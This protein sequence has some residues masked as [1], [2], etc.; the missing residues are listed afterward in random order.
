DTSIW[1]INGSRDLS[2]QQ[3]AVLQELVYY[4]DKKAQGYDMPAFKVIAEKILL[5]IAEQNPRTLAALRNINNVS[6]KLIH[7]HGRGLIDA[8]Q[9]GAK[10][11]KITQP[12]RQKYKNGYPERLE[13]LR[14]WRKNKAITMGV[15][16]DVIL[17]RDLMLQIATE[18]PSDAEHLTKILSP[19]PWRLEKYAS[20]IQSVLEKSRL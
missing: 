2:P 19:T 4:R 7:R 20:Q 10:A 17:P 1:R 16:S 14:G 18:N 6:D 8:V 11:N 13:T 5:A 12:P 3:A 15:E 9:R